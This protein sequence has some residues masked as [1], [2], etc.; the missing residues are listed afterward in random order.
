[1]K[2]LKN[3][4][5]IIG[6]FLGVAIIG[7]GIG[8]A[9]FS[10]LGNDPFNAMVL[11]ISGI[12][13]KDYTIVILLANAVCF[14]V[15]ILF[16]RKFLGIGTFVNWFGCGYVADFVMDT[17]EAQFGEQSFLPG[18]IA[19]MVLA[20]LV[21]SFGVAMYQT[22]NLGV[23][24]YDCIS[25]VISEKFK[26][27]YFWCRVFTDTVCVAI[28]LLFHGL[29]GIGTIICMVGLG[30]FVEFFSVKVAKKIIY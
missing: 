15:E 14:I 9:K 27:E 8:I 11:A 19:I 30:P 22:A 16:G 2:D 29:V 21:I 5:K 1:M 3:I 18:R 4:R 26:I 17:L 24:P 7:I 25:L 28:A 20:V 12:T 23:S 6:T 10:V 13:H